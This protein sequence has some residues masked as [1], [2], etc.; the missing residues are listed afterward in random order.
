MA[1]KSTSTVARLSAAFLAGTFLAVTAAPLLPGVQGTAEAFQRRGDDDEKQQRTKRSQTLSQALYEKVSK[2]NEKWEEGEKQ[3]AREIMDDLLEDKEDLS[4][5]E[6]AFVYSTLGNWAYS[7]DRVDQTIQYFERVRDQTDA[8]Q[9]F[10]DQAT[11]NLAQLYMGEEKPRKAVEY[12]EA[13]LAQNKAGDAS[14]TPHIILGQ[15]YYQLENYDKGIEN[16]EEAIAIARGLNQTV[17]KNW[18]QLLRAMYFQ[19]DDY[20][21]VREILEIMVVEYNDPS[22]WRQLSAIYGELDRRREQLAALEVAYKQGFL[23]K[24]SH[25]KNIAQFYM[26][27]EVPIKATWVLE[28]GMEEGKIEKNADNYEL[29]G[30]AYL[31]AQETDDAL[32]PMRRAAQAKE[33]SDAWQTYG[34]VLMGEQKW[35]ESAEAL[36]KAIALG[37]LDD[38]DSVRMVLGSAYVKLYEFDKAEEVLKEAR[39][40]EDYRKRANQWLAHVKEERERAKF[41]DKHLGTSYVSNQ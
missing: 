22:D 34:Q 26:Y 2:A 4:D 14:V 23:T 3:E 11:F 29:L 39:K 20:E 33:E 25:L 15:G 8:P 36:E 30:R 21:K 28:K 16:I 41:I 1:V 37:G 6:R 38:P 27:F 12:M 24:E 13:Y 35:E 17:R 31:M 18:W 19:K 7:E 9:S 5:Y 10:L 32:E 40:N